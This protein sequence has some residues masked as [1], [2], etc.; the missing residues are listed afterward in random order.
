MPEYSNLSDTDKFKFLS[1]HYVGQRKSLRK[2]ASEANVSLATIKN[3]CDRLGVPLRNKSEAQSNALETGVHKHP[4]KGTHRDEDTKRLIS[5]G[6]HDA[7]ENTIDKEERAKIS[8]ENWNKLDANKKQDIHRRAHIAVKKASQYGSKLERFL[9]EELLKKGYKAL[10]HQD[11]MLSNTKLQ[12]DLLIESM[13]VAIEVN[14]PS[15]HEAIWGN[16]SFVRTVNADKTKKDLLL[17]YGFIFI[18]VNQRKHLSQKRQ[19]I[20]LHNL[21]EVLEKIKK[22]RST[23]YYV[24]KDTETKE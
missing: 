8:R 20:I 10:W 24:I 18:V 21:L 22:D 23:T 17:H 16:E 9:L 11:R 6:M 12:V 4:T 19:Q 2:V 3:H 5:D 13:A 14:G 15:H 7:W 1:D